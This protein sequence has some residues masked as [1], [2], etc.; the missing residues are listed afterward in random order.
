MIHDEISIVNNH[1]YNLKQIMKA[2][3]LNKP[4]MKAITSIIVE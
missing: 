1:K 3:N 4:I 2:V